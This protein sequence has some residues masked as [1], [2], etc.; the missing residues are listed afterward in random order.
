[1]ISDYKLTAEDFSK[2]NITPNKKGASAL[3]SNKIEIESEYARF[4]TTG[5]YAFAL[6]IAVEH[7]MLRRIG[8]V[9]K[10]ASEFYA[11]YPDISEAAEYKNMKAN[12]IAES[13]NHSSPNFNLEKM[14]GN[15]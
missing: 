1:M 11:K 10:V 3:L 13:K 15:N 5:R 9:D 12:L 6:K 8:E 4:M 7:K 2:Y 14:L